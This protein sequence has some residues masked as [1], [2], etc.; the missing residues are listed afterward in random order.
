MQ[1]FFTGMQ[2]IFIAQFWVRVKKNEPVVILQWP[3]AID[4][5]GYSATLEPCFPTFNTL[6]D[7]WI[8]IQ[9]RNRKGWMLG[10]DKS[11]LLS[12]LT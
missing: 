3:I 10:H 12:V 2:L 11:E 6:A 4:K 5:G 8:V 1:I 7:P 9:E